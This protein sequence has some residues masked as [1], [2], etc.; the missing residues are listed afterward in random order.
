[1][2]ATRPSWYLRYFLGIAVAAVAMVVVSVLVLRMERATLVNRADVD[3]QGLMRL[4]LW[5]MDSW[6]APRLG[7]EAAR[8][9]QEYAPYYA[10]PDAYTAYFARIPTGD[11]I[12]PSPLLGF[13]SDIFPLHFQ[14][15]P[16]G[17]VT[18]PQVPLGNALDLTEYT[19]AYSPGELDAKRALLD[20]VSAAVDPQSLF[21][22][23]TLAEQQAVERG[24]ALLAAI[25][26]PP[27]VAQNFQIGQLESSETQWSLNQLE[28]QKRQQ[29][30]AETQ[31]VLDESANTRSGIVAPQT[32]TAT[33][34]PPAEVGPLAPVWITPHRAQSMQAKGTEGEVESHSR[35]AE[36]DVDITP[37]LS[38]DAEPGLVFVRRVRTAEGDT[39]QGVLGDWPALREQLIAQAADLLPNLRLVPQL[40]APADAAQSVWML[41]T[42]PAV[43]ECDPP[44]A[45]AAIP[46]LTPTRLTLGLSWLGLIVAGVA[47][48][49][50]LRSSIDY[51]ARRS[52]FASAVTHE[53]RTPLTTFRMYSEMLDEGMVTDPARQ[54]EYYKTMRSE[55]A[56]LSA[57]VENVLAYARLEDGRASKRV[58][59][60][61][62]GAL[63]DR[64]LPAL[65][66]RCEQVSGGGTG[67][68]PGGR[69]GAAPGGVTLTLDRRLGRGAPADAFDRERAFDADSVEQI[70]FNLVDNACKY[71]CDR[72]P[73]RIELAA[74][75]DDGHL[76]IRVRDYGRGIDP[77][78]AKRI[79]EPF[80]RGSIEPGLMI[81]GVGLGLALCRELATSIGATL[82][83][84]SPPDAGPGACFVLRV[85]LI[86]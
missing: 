38:G 26:A 7:R 4:A 70:L 85:P 41:A 16:G 29:Q 52:R 74:E 61:S 77:A 53:L 23:C 50:T 11:V 30:S 25:Q 58:D 67:D 44:T 42:I 59:R 36:V 72:D 19:Y 73:K 20:Q 64:V 12:A 78:V 47:V 18:S 49:L 69:G 13:E 80:D 33:P 34:A 75:I 8:P 57:L 62:A 55:S 60:L 27:Q 43:I 17:A 82:H 65:S 1:M 45:P 54:R 83:L 22:A 2:T 21:L 35:E 10:V 66:R 63:L 40:D 81:P 5:R 68:M 71:G 48:G 6:L 76:T 24:G 28:M 14:V 9:A 3:R 31:T 39:Y 37:V 79:F 86:G 84:E 56:R 51:G 15:E 32:G 46:L